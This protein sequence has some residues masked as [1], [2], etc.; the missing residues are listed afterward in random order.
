MRSGQFWATNNEWESEPEG[1][2]ERVGAAFLAV[3]VLATGLLL[4]FLYAAGFCTSDNRSPS[5]RSKCEFFFDLV[6]WF[7]VVSVFVITV[8]VTLL[9]RNPNR[10]LEKG[11]EGIHNASN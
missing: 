4:A 2:L 1:R 7:G 6:P 5:A 8:I 11:E 10:N 9:V 3:V